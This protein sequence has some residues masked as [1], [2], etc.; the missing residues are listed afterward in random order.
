[1]KK[2]SITAEFGVITPNAT[3]RNRLFAK[4]ERLGSAVP[5]KFG[6]VENSEEF[7]FTIRRIAKL[8]MEHKCKNCLFFQ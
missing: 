8:P 4:H 1:M 2:P 5:L 6:A 3:Q 7:G